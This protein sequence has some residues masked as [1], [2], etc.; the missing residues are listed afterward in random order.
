MSRIELP[1]ASAFSFDDMKARKR[2]RMLLQMEECLESAFALKFGD[3]GVQTIGFFIAQFADEGHEVHYSHGYSFE[4]EHDPG[5]LHDADCYGHELEMEFEPNDPRWSTERPVLDFDE[6]FRALFPPFDSEGE[7]IEAF[8]SYAILSVDTPAKLAPYCLWHKNTD[9]T[10][11]RTVVGVMHQPEWMDADV[12]VDERTGFPRPRPSERGRS[13]TPVSQ[14]VLAPAALTR[15]RVLMQ[16]EESLPSIF[17]ARPGEPL[18]QTVGLLVARADNDSGSAVHHRLS[19]SI[20]VEYDPARLKDSHNLMRAA[21][22][23]MNRW[24][25][26]PPILP[27]ELAPAFSA[28]A[29]PDF[30][31]F[32]VWHRLPDG[33]VRRH[34]VRAAQTEVSTAAR[35]RASLPWT[36]K[37]FVVA[38]SFVLALGLLALRMW[39]VSS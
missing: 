13:S 1:P 11:R 38:A 5:R 19:F 34:I 21:D 2:E 18:V 15:E 3:R 17:A 30:T 28:Y 37:A 9:G 25:E 26:L 12:D 31:V 27:E 14:T 4:V 24:Q 20:D 16:L 22:F 29:S 32:C 10:F 35:V 36:V 33:A 6:R 39:L 7:M 8:A 23:E